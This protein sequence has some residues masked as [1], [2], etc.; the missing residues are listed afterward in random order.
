MARTWCRTRSLR[1]FVAL[2]ELEEDAPLRALA[3]PDRPQQGARRL[4]TLRSRAIRA[5]E[6]I[7]AADER[8]PIQKAQIPWRC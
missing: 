4:R 2:D 6:P 8:S 1:A 3:V 5:A 7:E